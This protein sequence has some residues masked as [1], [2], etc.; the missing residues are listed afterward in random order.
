MYV[1]QR[2]GT[3]TMVSVSVKKQMIGVLAKKVIRGIAVRMIVSVIK[4]VQ[5]LNI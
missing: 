5:W 1:M 3:M 4:N 2:H